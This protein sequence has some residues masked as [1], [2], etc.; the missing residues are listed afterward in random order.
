MKGVID[1]IWENKID[2]GKAYFVLKIGREKYSIW[3]KKYMEGLEEW[4]LP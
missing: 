2:D 4:F 3:D 1:K